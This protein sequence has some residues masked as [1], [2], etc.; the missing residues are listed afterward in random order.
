MPLPSILKSSK[1]YAAQG[2]VAQVSSLFASLYGEPNITKHQPVVTV[3]FETRLEVVAEPELEEHRWLQVRLPDDRAAWL[4]RGD[5]TFDA[6]K[7]TVPELIEF[8][9]RFLGLPYLW[10]GVSTFGYDCSGL[11]QMLCRRRGVLMPRDADMQAGW[12][13]VTP[14]DKHELQPGD[15]LYFGAS[16]KKITHTGMYMGN[17]EFINATAHEHPVIQICKLDDP[18]WTKLFVAARRLK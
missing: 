5:M 3:P 16:A 15:L 4:Q 12:T 7:L 1:P 6:Q 11:T 17:G 9:K 10:G 18:H 8:S 2:K 13:G 14:V